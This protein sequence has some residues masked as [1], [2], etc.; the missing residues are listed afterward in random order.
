MVIRGT[1]QSFYLLFF[2]GG[3]G[4]GGGGGMSIV[5]FMHGATELASVDSIFFFNV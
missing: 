2:F 1:Y 3:G 5:R 4:G